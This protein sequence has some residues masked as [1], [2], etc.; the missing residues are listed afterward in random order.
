MPENDAG[1]KR[2]RHLRHHRQRLRQDRRTA[3]AAAR[4][5]A[6]DV[7]L[8]LQRLGVDEWNRR[9]RVR[10]A[11]GV[12]AAPEDGPGFDDD[13]AGRG[14]ELGP[15]GHARDSLHHL[16]DEGAERLILADVRS[17]VG[18]IHVRAGEVQLEAVRAGV[19]AR[20]GEGAPALE[21]LVVAGSGHDRG[22][23]HAR[24]ERLLDALDPR[25]PPVERLVRDELPVPGRVQ[26]AAA[27]LVHRE[28]A[29]LG[30]IAEEL[31]LGAGDVGDRVH[32]DGLGDDTA[33]SGLK[34]VEDVVLG[35]GRRRRREQER[36]LEPKA[37]KR[38]RKI[39]CHDGP[40]GETRSPYAS[41]RRS[42]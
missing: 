20:R 3:Q 42:R 21:L 7:H 10:R 27:P 5:A 36:V 9:K 38:H 14:R 41:G 34:G 11:H 30:V 2:P 32:A 33:P 25:Q 12:A 24:G 4:D 40:Y 17:H 29:G 31:G 18:P 39:G 16:G 19:L 1:W 15:D 37:R 22:D 28:D 23:E 6:V 13:V 35:L 26:H 8:E